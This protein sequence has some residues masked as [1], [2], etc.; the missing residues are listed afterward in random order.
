MK[1]LTSGYIKSGLHKIYYATYGNPQGNPWIFC[2]GGPGYHTVPKSNLKF[3]NLKKDYVILFDQRGAGKSRPSTELKN[4]TT[5]DLVKD[6]GLILDKLKLSKVSVLGGSWGSTL[7]LCFAISNPQRVNN[8][9]VR[10]IFLGRKK[11]IWSIY[12]PTNKWSPEQKEKFDLTLGSLIKQYKLKNLL[13]DGLKIIK[14]NNQDS[15]Q[16][17]KKWAAYEDLICHTGWSWLDFDSEYLKMA[18]DISSIEIHY[19]INNCFLPENYI[20]KNIKN[21]AHIPLYI[22]QGNMDMC[23]PKYQAL[24]LAD[25]HPQV[26]LYLDPTG[27][28][29]NNEAMNKVM[30]KMVS[31]STSKKK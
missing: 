7:A 17:V 31:Q 14:K 8:L 16:F 29:S 4:N 11:D 27:G 2:H 19:F 9:V 3:F 26:E 23:T 25:A 5:Q 28:H 12:K 20:L 15:V 30:T 21:I 13:V 1:E 18:K 22:V 10:G 6:M 24:E